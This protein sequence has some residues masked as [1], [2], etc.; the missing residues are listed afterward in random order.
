VATAEVAA[1]SWEASAKPATRSI[2]SNIRPKRKVAAL[3][4]S[5]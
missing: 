5:D 3:F 2:S 4:K 1:P